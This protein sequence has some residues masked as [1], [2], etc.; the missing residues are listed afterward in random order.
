MISRRSIF[1]GM[2]AVAV[3]G[4]LPEILHAVDSPDKIESGLVET[5]Q[6]LFLMDKDK[7]G[8]VSHIEFTRFMEEEFERLDVNHDGYLDL[9]ELSKF[10]H[11]P[12]GGHR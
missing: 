4:T 9:N 8:R 1:G 2:A 6:L 11:A 3:A 5:K 7:D 12:A 10:H